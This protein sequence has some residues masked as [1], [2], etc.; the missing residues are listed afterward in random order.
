MF[1]SNLKIGFN[2]I[3]HIAYNISIDI[4]CKSRCN[5]LSDISYSS[6]VVCL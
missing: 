6:L 1:Y 5:M 3:L 4:L 2:I